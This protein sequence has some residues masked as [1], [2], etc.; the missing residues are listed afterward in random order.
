MSH[1][2]HSEGL[3]SVTRYMSPHQNYKTQCNMIIYDV[4]LHFQ[5]IN[6]YIC[7]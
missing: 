7:S 4:N 1:I 6:N 5:Q 2:A 3:I